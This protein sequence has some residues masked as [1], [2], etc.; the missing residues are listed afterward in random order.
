MLRKLLFAVLM[1]LACAAQAAV[2]SL[3]WGPK[4]Q[5]VDS[6]GAPMSSGTLTFYVAGTS[7]PQNTYTDSTG[8]TANSNPVT[9]NSRGEPANEIWLTGGASYKAVLKDSSGSTVWTVDNLAGIND[10]TAQAGNEWVAPGL[11]PTYISA[12]SFSLT[13]D[14]RTIFHVG[15]RLKT[16]NSGGTIYSTITAVAFTS[17]TT[18]TVAND[19]GSLDS[20]LSAV[21]YGLASADNPSI[22]PAVI[23]RKGTAVASAASVDIWSISGDYVH[24][25]GNTGPI[26]SFGTAPYAG[27]QRTVI[28]DSTPTIT[29]NATTLVLPGGA[30]IT[31]AA[32][33]R[34]IVRADTTANMVV[35]AYIT[36]AGRTVIPTVLDNVFRVLD[37]ADTT[38]QVAVEAG[39][40]TTGTTRTVTVPDRDITLHDGPTSGTVTAAAGQTSIDFTIPAWATRITVSLNELSTNS[41]SRKLIQLGDAGGVE[42]TSYVSTSN[43]VNQ[44]SGTSGTSSTAGFVIE[45]AAA[46]EIISGHYTFTLVNAA[47]FTWIGSGVMKKGTTHVVLSAGSKALSAAL[48]TVRMTTVNG[49][50]TFDAGSINVQYQ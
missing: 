36:A 49:T 22:S 17:L 42:T 34:M 30:N 32:N 21:S 28:F 29:H 10:V 4:P 5:F 48:T 18:V 1:A 6:N 33:D 2:Y 8:S 24:V 13:G 9:L 27:A 12:T 23:Y 16:T 41:T 25:T 15:R 19:S 50:D 3:P 14:Q 38:K 11:S 44:A 7:T 46:A 40:I 35:V 37:S 20:G 31:A 43:D 39:S 45:S 47:T 26:T